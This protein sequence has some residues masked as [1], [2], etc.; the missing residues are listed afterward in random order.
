MT[1]GRVCFRLL[2]SGLASSGM[3]CGAS[4]PPVTEHRVAVFD[5]T[6]AVRLVGAGPDTL[7][8]LHGGPVLGT[9][10][11]EHALRPLAREH[12]LLVFALRGSP[13][14]RTD[15]DIASQASDLEAVRS[16]FLLKR[17]ALVAHDYGAAVA[18]HYVLAHPEVVDRIVLLGPL[19]PRQGYT[20]DLSRVA[21]DSARTAE[22]W[23]ALAAGWDTLASA[24]ACERFWGYWLSPAAVTAPR[25]VHHVA[26]D[27]CRGQAAYRD[28]ERM[29]RTAIRS[30]GHWDWRDSLSLVAARTLVVTGTEC[31]RGCAT[32]DSVRAAILRHGQATWAAHLPQGLY[33]EVEGDPQL[34]WVGTVDLSGSITAFLAGERPEGALQLASPPATPTPA[35]LEPTPERSQ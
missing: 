32:A 28:G 26:P 8:V 30:L 15:P 17:L 3:G 29:Q 31:T 13:E 19:Y 1:L 35:R 25:T 16:H 2:A 5:D 14:R 34:P 22:F 21:L 11:L 10:Y 12:A 9:A 4:E 20:Y 18:V 24:P 27:I 6:I 7:V 23:R 33:L